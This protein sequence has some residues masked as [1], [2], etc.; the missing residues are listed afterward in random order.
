LLAAA[1]PSAKRIGMLM[2]QK[3]IRASRRELRR[4]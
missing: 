3:S 4:Q 1:E 2:L